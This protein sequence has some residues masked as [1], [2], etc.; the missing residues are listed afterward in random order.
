ML[1]CKDASHLV[2]HCQDRPLNFRERW[3]LRIHLWMCGNCRRFERQIAL[4]R[5]L[6]R[7]S[8]PRTETEIAGIELTAEARERISRALA[9]Q[10]SQSSDPST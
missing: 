4:M 5:R 7:Q 6:L 10:Q 3:G 1:T 8:D 2:S 9:D